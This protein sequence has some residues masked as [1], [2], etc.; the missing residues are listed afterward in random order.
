MRLIVDV[1]RILSMRRPAYVCT[2]L[3]AAVEII[4]FVCV[5]LHMLVDASI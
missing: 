1:A 5:S 2:W 4:L 3:N